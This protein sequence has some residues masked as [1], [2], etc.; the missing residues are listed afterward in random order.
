MI[1]KEKLCLLG[2]SGHTFIVAPK[3]NT[4]PVAQDMTPH[5]SQ[6]SVRVDHS[7]CHRCVAFHFNVFGMTRP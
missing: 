4:I 1:V 6:K 7:L 2:Y 3:S 5:S